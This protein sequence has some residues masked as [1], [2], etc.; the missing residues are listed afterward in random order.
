M[1][2]WSDFDFVCRKVLEY[3]AQGDPI[4]DVLEKTPYSE[5]EFIIELVRCYLIASDR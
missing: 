3:H 1:D 5:T 2:N 4:K